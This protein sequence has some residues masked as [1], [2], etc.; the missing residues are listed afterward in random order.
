MTS[1]S[2]L[3]IHKSTQESNALQLSI[4]KDVE[5]LFSDWMRHTPQT[6][7]PSASHAAVKEGTLLDLVISDLDED[8]YGIA[9]H[10]GKKYLVSG[11]LPGETVRSR[12][13]HSG[14]RVSF[15]ATVKILR[16]SPARLVN[17][18]CAVH[19]C[20]GCP[21]VAMKYPAQLTWKGAFIARQMGGYE[22][23]STA[24][25]LPVIASPAQLGY[26]NTAKLVVAGKHAQPLIG[27]YRRNTHDVID[28]V[29]CPLHHPLINRI[30][31]AVRTGIRKGKVDIYSPRTGNG[32][33]R[34]LV[35]RVSETANQ[36]M[37]V[38]VTSGKSYNE[39]HHLAK[40]VQSAVPEVVV[41][42]QNSNSS[43]G[44]VIL[45]DHDR[46][47]SRE[48][49]LTATIGTTRFTLSPRSFF[50][51]NSGGAAILYDTVRDWAGLTGSELVIDL[52]CGVGGI[53][54]YLAG[55]AREV[56]GIEVVEA[57][58]ADAV[59]NA[60]LNDIRN[61]RFETGDA[62]ELLAELQN[63]HDRVDLVILNPPRKGCEQKVLERVAALGP[64]K[65][66]YVSCS[67]VSLARDLDI[68]AGLGYRTDRIQP[69]DMFPQ[70][71][72]VENVALLTRK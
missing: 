13:T 69:V 32:L 61:C 50:Q 53:S 64:A 8:G 54:L 62:A 57:A 33:L 17:S 70:T 49:S 35:I 22:S 10:E 38:F 43:E 71:P 52:Y 14:R 2:T 21:L 44:N 12:V 37:V 65:L 30:I 27:M 24:R 19:D 28:M 66:I 46:F 51:V 72:H 48:R 15:A 26:R 7:N 67:P 47:L 45:G 6:P 39:I 58:V 56:I 36:A 68:L 41:T 11:A 20:D 59:R 1:I 40:H 60:R 34:Y 18:P 4:D 31:A 29:D 25:I 63:E 55:K 23:L 42:A 3:L 5:F 9:H 16:H